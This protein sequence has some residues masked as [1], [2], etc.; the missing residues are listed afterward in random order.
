MPTANAPV[1]DIVALGEPLVELSATEMGPL[2]SVTHFKVGC[3]GDTSNFAVAACRLGGRAGYISRVGEDPFAD[4][5]YDCWKK[6][7]V[8]CSK[9]TRDR[10][11]A[12]GIYFTSRESGCHHFTYYR[13]H[14]AA[15]R[16]EPDD[17]PVEYIR[18]ARWLHVS[19]I[20]QAISSSA[21]KTV[22]LAVDAAR[23][24]GLVISYDPNLRL[25]L[26]PLEK[27]RAAIRRMAARADVLLPSYEDALALTE[28]KRPEAI[29][30]H[31]LSLGC[32]LVI[33]KMGADGALL[34]E[35]SSAD[36]CGAKIEKISAFSVEVVDASG[37]GDTFDA[38][39]VVAR[40][41]GHPV[42]ECVRFANAAGA[43]VAAG[44]GTITPIPSREE[45]ELFM[46]T[47]T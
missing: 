20:S 34:G 8:D 28:E 35:K 4:I 6:E 9:V 5:L 37:A 11:G 41:E 1:P 23:E 12:T 30:S 22:D 26:W 2:S 17:L 38:A 45:V 42:V 46:E 43:M 29:V 44:I 24:A 19:G 7:G 3:G 39:F 40:L 18:K 31:Y 36:R 14:S 15:S 33:L 16:M 25:K 10:G 47:Q 21:A 27:A 13:Q 32:R